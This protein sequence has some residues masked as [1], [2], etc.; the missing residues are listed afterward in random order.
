M[1]NLNHRWSHWWSHWW[2]LCAHICNTDSVS[3]GLLRFGPLF[4]PHRV[5]ESSFL[6][7][8]LEEFFFGYTST[9]F[10]HK[11]SP[12]FLLWRLLRLK[13]AKLLGNVFGEMKAI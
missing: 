2:M 3:F 12:Y 11:F 8:Y 5:L 4:S 13:A 1:M 7:Q 9:T 10:A 6:F